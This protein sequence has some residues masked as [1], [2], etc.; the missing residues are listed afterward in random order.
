MGNGNSQPAA[1]DA[2][3][4]PAGATNPNTAGAVPTPGDEDT[5]QDEQQKFTEE[6][7]RFTQVYSL[8][9]T[10]F[11]VD[12]QR[13][14][15]GDATDLSLICR[16]SL[17]FYKLSDQTLKRSTIKSTKARKNKSK[18]GEPPSYL[19]DIDP[20]N[21]SSVPYS[22]NDQ[23]VI[24]TPI[25]LLLNVRR[26][27]VRLSQGKHAKDESRTIHKLQFT[28]DAMC[29]CSIKMDIY[30][31]I[32][33]YNSSNS[34]PAVKLYRA[35]KLKGEIGMKFEAEES[36]ELE[37][38]TIMNTLRRQNIQSP[39]GISGFYIVI[40]L[41]RVLPN[42]RADPEYQEQITY[43]HIEQANE[44]LSKTD[45]WSISAV[46]Q[47]CTVGKIQFLL[48]DIFGIEN[49]KRLND[50]KIGYEKPVEGQG[51]VGG[52]DE[53]GSCVVC[54]SEPRD[55]I[56]LPCRHLC[57]CSSCADKLRY[58]H[59]N[60]PFC[61]MPFQALQGVSAKVEKEGRPRILLTIS[62]K[63]NKFYVFPLFCPRHTPRP[64]LTHS[65]PTQ[66]LCS[67]RL[68][69]I[70]HGRTRR[71][72]SL[73]DAL[74]NISKPH[75]KSRKEREKNRRE[76]KNHKRERASQAANAARTHSRLEK[77]RRY[78]EQQA[79]RQKS[80]PPRQTSRAPSKTTKGISK[81]KEE[82][83]DSGSSSYSDDSSSSEDDDDKTNDDKKKS[84]NK[85]N[86][87]TSGTSVDMCAGGS[88]PGSSIDKASFSEI[89]DDELRGESNDQVLRREHL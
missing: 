53:D 9:G 79:A 62:L 82:T 70:K 18:P 76:E 33:N 63:K 81:K 61:R 47:V 14:L 25:H 56:M 2:T 71:E 54:L 80:Q 50:E 68:K 23:Q 31:D 73:A 64:L 77:E 88:G 83:E 42:G 11:E 13:Y 17:S 10:R 36:P 51:A 78:K 24:A 21:L 67:F 89:S 28:F 74:N 85:K 49:K 37:M 66:T 8:G 35:A 65:H 7:Q 46:R 87:D 4:T 30:A 32:Q 27:S 45:N 69:A 16:Q 40:L 26:A 15:C 29:T 55:T 48:Q 58:Q 44:G 86:E 75:S 39:T 19:D 22:S 20:N 57:L 5:P 72:Y 84:K 34:P 1:A 12:K 3:T 41:Y 60:C 38:S 43:V 59:G 6:E 52:D